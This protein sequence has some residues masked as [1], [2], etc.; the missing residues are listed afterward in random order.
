[1]SRI[2]ASAG[3]GGGG[4]GGGGR[5]NGSKFEK[6][7]L[8]LL[9]SATFNLVLLLT[10]LFLFQSSSSALKNCCI[11]GNQISKDSVLYT[12]QSV[13]FSPTNY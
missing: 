9:P 4:G 6:Y 1:M 12:P 8:N 13:L 2:Y 11:P 7:S 10:L 5:E 3:G